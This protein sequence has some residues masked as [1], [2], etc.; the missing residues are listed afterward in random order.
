VAEKT[1]R[2]A[3]NARAMATSAVAVGQSSQS[4]SGA[5]THALATAQAVA[6]A[7]EELSE[8]IAE[9]AGQVNAAK[10]VTTG[11]VGAASRAESTIGRLSEAVERIGAVS[12]LIGEIA[13]QTN[14]LALNAMIEAA[15]RRRR[16][17]LRRGGRR[18]EGACLANREGD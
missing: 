16:A 8:S 2:L 11:A 4:V 13:G 3:S 15:R 18:G 6:T 5:A 12:R 9:I 7:S 1:G 14:L 10:T 17:W